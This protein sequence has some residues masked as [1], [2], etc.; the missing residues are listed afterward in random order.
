M[1]LIFFFFLFQMLV[2]ILHGKSN[3]YTTD[4]DLYKINL[5]GYFIKNLYKK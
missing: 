5:Y 2:I 4:C 1:L 3:K